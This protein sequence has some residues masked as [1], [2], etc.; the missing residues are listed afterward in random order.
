MTRRT[1]FPLLLVT[2]LLGFAAYLFAAN[3]TGQPLIVTSS[4]A[5]P[6]IQ[7][8]TYVA[9]CKLRPTGDKFET[10]WTHTVQFDRPFAVAPRVMLAPRGLS[11]FNRQGK[12]GTFYQLHSSNITPRGFDILIQG[13]HADSLSSV[14]VDWIAVVNSPTAMSVK[15][16]N[17][18]P[19]R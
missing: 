16:L 6:D 12:P 5:V 8:G 13:A 9:E 17:S 1:H 15:D 18:Y 14:S 19:K 10:T 7:M 3:P 2:I 4:P 11:I